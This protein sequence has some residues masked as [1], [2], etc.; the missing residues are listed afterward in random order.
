MTVP[1]RLEALELGQTKIL[2]EIGG[3]KADVGELQGTLRVW[4]DERRLA[5]AEAEKLAAAMLRECNTKHDQIDRR[6]VLAETRL[7]DHHGRI[8]KLEKWAGG[9][10]ASWSTTKTAGIIF[11][12]VVGIV[13]TTTGIVEAIT[14]W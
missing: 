13:G 4:I 14:H 2:D 5:A 11:A 10:I 7:D 1:A 6:F 3:V 9:R 8:V 12:A